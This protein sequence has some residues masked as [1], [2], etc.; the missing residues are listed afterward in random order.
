MPPLSFTP[1]WLFLNNPQE[2]KLATAKFC[3][4][5]KRDIS[6]VF[7]RMRGKTEYSC[8]WTGTGVPEMCWSVWTTDTHHVYNCVNDWYREMVDKTVN[9][10]CPLKEHKENHE[11]LNN[12][13]FGNSSNRLK[14]M[15]K[16]TTLKGRV[17]SSFTFHLFIVRK[18]QALTRSQYRHVLNFF[19]IHDSSR[20]EVKIT[21]PVR[22]WT[23]PM[24]L[25]CELVCACLV[26]HCALWRKWP[27]IVRLFE[28]PEF[29][30]N[31]WTQ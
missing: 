2:W 8:E 25:I 3:N 26:S 1:N 5:R 23:S 19:Q 6:N 17:D 16:I 7:Q 11:N 31:P 13:T 15:L 9:N 21:T 29:T 24:V 27:I 18:H 20:P 14:G 4:R 28:T 22:P 10:H 30:Q 12:I